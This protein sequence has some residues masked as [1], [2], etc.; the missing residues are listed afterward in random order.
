M[1]QKSAV[2]S[3]RAFVHRYRWSHSSKRK[4]YRRMLKDGKVRLVHQEKDGWLYE[5]IE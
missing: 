4:R 1:Q 5:H 2:M 3:K